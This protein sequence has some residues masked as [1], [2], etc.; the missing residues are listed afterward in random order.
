MKRGRKKITCILGEKR[1]YSFNCYPIEYQKLRIEFEK[2]KRKRYK[3]YVK[4]KGDYD[5]GETI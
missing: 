4:E 2:L 1:N 3:Y 5:Y